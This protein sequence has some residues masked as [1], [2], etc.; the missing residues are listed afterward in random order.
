MKGSRRLVN[1]GAGGE[2]RVRARWQAAERKFRSPSQISTPAP[3][4]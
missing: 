1:A 4:V 2:P 3:M